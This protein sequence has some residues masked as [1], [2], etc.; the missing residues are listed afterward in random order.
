LIDFRYHLVSIVSVFFALAVGIVLGAGPLEGEIGDTLNREIAGL[1]Q[2]KTTLNDELDQARAGVEARDAYLSAARADLLGDVL[3]NRS[4][5]LVALPGAQRSVVDATS[6]TLAVAGA[7]VV[8]RTAMAE[9]WVT[10][11]DGPATTRKAV[12]DRVAAGAGIDIDDVSPRAGRDTLLARLLIRPASP[13]EAVEPDLVRDSLTALGDAD[14]LSVDVEAV[15]PADL[16]VVVSAT[17][18]RGPADQPAA[19]AEQW[20]DLAVAFDRRSLG[21]LV[22]AD[23][24][25]EEEG[26]SVLA[27][28]RDDTAASDGVSSVDDASTP[29][30]QASLVHGLA[31][32]SAGE[33]GQYGLGPGAD[34][35]FAPPAAP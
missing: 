7:R 29:M 13:S 24:V 15:Q 23:L 16:V 8:S 3:Q 19:T 9:N 18:P 17:V 5:A 2:D 1:R 32:Q 10:N 35:P 11:D 31:Q 28:L 21:T 12:V 25:S 4:V 33:S 20:V 27:V 14:L 34:A 6:E 22:A 26:V 30:G